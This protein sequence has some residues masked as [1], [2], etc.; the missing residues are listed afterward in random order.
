[1]QT[2]DHKLHVYRVKI[3]F[4]Q[5]KAQPEGVKLANLTVETIAGNVVTGAFKDPDVG[6][7][8]QE[9]SSAYSALQ[10]SHLEIIPTSDIEKTQPQQ[11]VILA[12]YSSSV[13]AV[14]LPNTSHGSPAVICRWQLSVK[15]QKVHSVFDLIA[16][17]SSDGKPKVF[18]DRELVAW[19]ANLVNLEKI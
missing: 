1:M 3:D 2:S 18:Y 7:L 12:I 4:V 19:V 9:E 14:G 5:D 13:N 17:K 8:G 10:L 16:Q 6:L 11:P 15:E